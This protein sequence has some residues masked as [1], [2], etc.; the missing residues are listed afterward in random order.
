MRDVD[1]AGQSPAAR[2]SDAQA[3]MVESGT[4]SEFS[5]AAQTAW[6]TYF[7]GLEHDPGQLLTSA[8][9]RRLAR[10]IA[11]GD[12]E[13]RQQLIA[14]N[15]R[16][17]FHVVSRFRNLGVPLE[18]LIQEGNLGLIEAVDRFDPARGCR[19][20]TYALLWIRGAVMR[21][22]SRLRAGMS[23][24][25]R[26]AQS[27]ARLRREE[28]VLAQELLRQPT[29]E[30]L[31]RRVGMTAQQVDEARQMSRTPNSLESME[32]DDGRAVEEWLL[33]ANDPT[34][35]DHVVR[36]ELQVTISRSLQ[37]L[38][39][40]EREVLRLRFGLDADEP[41][42]LAEVGRVLDISRQRAR[43]LEQSALRRLRSETA[44]DFGLAAAGD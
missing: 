9:E 6:R 31:G 25:E 38:T 44:Q 33:P 17:V 18:D 22:A 40:R 41:R 8:E 15:Y 39:P 24:S 32:S 27:A 42:S 37:V 12:N 3:V 26:L 20:N 5:A 19:F 29:A 43:E 7:P 36:S 4:E 14:A 11:L 34:A 16:L 1:G 21:A 23:V 2:D 30:E 10:R 28:E 13:A 35:A